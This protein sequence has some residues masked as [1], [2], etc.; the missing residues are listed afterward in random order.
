[1]ILLQNSSG[2]C[3]KVTTVNLRFVFLHYLFFKSLSLTAIT[4]ACSSKCYI[5]SCS[6]GTTLHFPIANAKSASYSLGFERRYATAGIVSSD[7][8]ANT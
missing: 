8:S 7:A 1:M 5:E 4:A 6:I 3:Q 2:I